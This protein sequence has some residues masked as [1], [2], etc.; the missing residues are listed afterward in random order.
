MP[1]SP[2]Q[3]IPDHRLYLSIQ[4]Q[5]FLSRTYSRFLYMSY[6]AV[7]Q[8][9]E[10]APVTQRARVRSLVGTN[11]LGEVF[12]VFSSPVRQMSGNFRPQ[13]PRISF[14]HHYHQSSFIS[15]TGANDVRSRRALK[16][17]IYTFLYMSL[18]AWVCAWVNES[19]CEYACL[20]M[21]VSVFIRVR[22]VDKVWICS[23]EEFLEL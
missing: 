19:V 18:C 9:V 10:C 23:A 7:G 21:W 13:G 17:Q 22:H 16:P 8:M 12:W 2:Q 4:L 1:W 15:P 3:T 5:K 14:G 11:F 20:S 6:T